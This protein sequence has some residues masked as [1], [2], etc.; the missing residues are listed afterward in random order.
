VRL[1]A[2]W[3]LFFS[4]GQAKGGN[5]RSEGFVPIGHGKCP[6]TGAVVVFK[7][8]PSLPCQERVCV[9]TCLVYY[10]PS[11]GAS[12]QL[13]S[14]QLRVRCTQSYLI[15]Y[16]TRSTDTQRIRI[17]RIIVLVHHIPLL[18]MG[19]PRTVEWTRLKERHNGPTF[20]F[21]WLRNQFHVSVIDHVCY[22]SRSSVPYC[23]G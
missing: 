16:C 12:A 14:G 4:R 18:Q 19:R 2:L 10:K 8:R 1:G 15:D 20:L 17:N 3:L 23:M 5:F 21:R 22:R 7:Q 9:V 13:N 11:D 6:G